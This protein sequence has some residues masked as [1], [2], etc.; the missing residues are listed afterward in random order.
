MAKFTAGVG[1]GQASG[2]VAGTTYSHNRYGPYMRTKA[3]P[4]DPRSAKQLVVRS[5]MGNLS[6]SW[7]ALT[8]AQRLAWNTQAVGITFTDALGNPYNPTG[9]QL[10]V[11]LN[12]NRV[13]LSLAIATTPPAL[14]TQAVITTGSSTAVSGTGVQIVTFAP[15]IAAA[16]FYLLRATAPFSAGKSYF[17]R[18]LYK[19]LAVLT[20]ADVSPY[21]ATTVYANVFGGLTA[22]DATKKIAFQLVPFSSSGW[23]GTGYAWTT[24]I[25]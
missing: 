25:S 7:R 9:A 13:M 16:S 4:T 2:S 20:N 23:R 22:G 24:I 18:S 8:A 14:Q 3:I 1:F 15:A 11:G 10:Y 21:T 17:P 12:Q 6:Q 5:R 19:D